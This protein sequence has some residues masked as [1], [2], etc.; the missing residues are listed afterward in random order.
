MCPW[1]VAKIRIFGFRLVSLS[2]LSRHRSVISPYQRQLHGENPYS[3]CVYNLLCRFNQLFNLL[4]QHRQCVLT[5][6]WICKYISGYRKLIEGGWGK[7]TEVSLQQQSG[8]DSAVL[9]KGQNVVLFFLTAEVWLL[10]WAVSRSEQYRESNSEKTHSTDQLQCWTQP[11]GIRLL[12]LSQ[13]HLRQPG[14][15]HRRNHSESE[16]GDYTE[17]SDFKKT[18]NKMCWRVF[19]S[20]RHS[21]SFNAEV[22]QLLMPSYSTWLLILI[23]WQWIFSVSL[24]QLFIHPRRRQLTDASFPIWWSLWSSARRLE[25]CSWSCNCWSFN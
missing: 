16:E 19:N 11:G 18:S 13:S 14:F 7:M 25:N 22:L 20:L 15:I 9:T 17:L 5:S 6:Y 21:V 10:C 12:L 4:R 8:L 1:C 24:F 3:W 23:M 2:W